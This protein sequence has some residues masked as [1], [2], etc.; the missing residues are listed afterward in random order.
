MDAWLKQATETPVDDN[1]VCLVCVCVCV[2]CVCVCV[3]IKARTQ[4]LIMWSFSPHCS[5]AHFS[6]A[7]L[8]T[9]RVAG[10]ATL[11]IPLTRTPSEPGG[12][13]KQ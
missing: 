4:T 10:S 1:I 2:W 13:I 12:G 5:K 9:K 6:K 11:L 8:G 7:G 3:C